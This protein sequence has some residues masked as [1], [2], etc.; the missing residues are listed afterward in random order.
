MSVAAPPL[1]SFEHT[2]AED[3]DGL[4]VEQAPVPVA[5]PSLVILNEQLA[6][7]LGVD[8]EQL[9]SADGVAGLAG[10][11]VPTGARPLAQVYAG[12]QFGG[13]SPRLGDGRA[14]LLGE[15]IDTAGVRRD[16]HLKGSGRT[17]FARGGD[18]RA[19]LGPMLREYL[20]GEAMH[21]LGIATTRALAVVSTG[22]RVARETLLPGA[23]LARVASS[24][25]RVGTFQYAASTG[26]RDVLLRLL[27]HAVARHLPGATDESPADK[28]LALYRHVVRAQA[29]LIAS[30]M[31][32]GFIHGVMNTDN[33][34]ILGETI[35]YGPCAFMD[36]YDPATV[37]SSIDH[38]GRYAFGNQPAIGA[39]NLSRFAETL[40]PLVDDDADRAVELLTAELQ[41]YP[42]HFDRAWLGGMRAKLGIADG[43]EEDLALVEDLLAMLQTAGADYTTAFRALAGT[44][45]DSSTTLPFDGSGWVARWR[46]RIGDGASHDDTADAMDLV[47]PIYIPRNHL[48]EAALAAATDGDLGP[49][50]ELI[51]VL[52]DPYTERPDHA[53]YAEPAPPE[54][55][56][57]RTFCGT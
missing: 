39:W 43:R 57:Y 49:F 3:L 52:G 5:E 42:E 26:D 15:V 23:V 28:A 10:A 36:G 18:G 40:V 12:H 41:R 45:R 56:P 9:R 48:V 30:W 7:E 29:E 22:E 6:D 33:M 8:V 2:F 27:D 24:H 16:L 14:L 54:F 53:R 25:L 44:L 50:V 1:F 20:F 47:N 13:Y 11:A 46:E 55:G 31:H 4:Y 37:Y 51:A 34:S 21:A 35:D 38:G 19:V 32:I 17:P